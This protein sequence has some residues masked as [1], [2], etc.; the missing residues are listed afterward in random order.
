MAVSCRVEVQL[1][2]FFVM[3]ALWQCEYYYEAK[4]GCS[5]TVALLI[6]RAKLIGMVNGVPPGERRAGVDRIGVRS[7]CI[8]DDGEG[9]SRSCN[10][11]SAA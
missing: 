11:L 2:V 6:G 10:E 7:A 3:S 9:G 8:S 4:P 1:L 5:G